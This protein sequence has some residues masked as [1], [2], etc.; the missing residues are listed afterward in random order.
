MASLI[1]IY[2]NA[3][4]TGTSGFTGLPLY[5]GGFNNGIDGNQV[6]GVGGI[7]VGYNNWTSNVYKPTNPSY[8][9]AAIVSVFPYQGDQT[10]S[11][12]STVSPPNAGP[13]QGHY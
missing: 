11:A 9:N 7:G 8:Q 13:Y 10:Y 4:T 6:L 12:G 3:S 1:D 2:Q 5:Y